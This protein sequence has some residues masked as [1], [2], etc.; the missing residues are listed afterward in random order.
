MAN[1]TWVITYNC[2]DGCKNVGVH[3][4]SITLGDATATARF[5]ITAV[6]NPDMPVED[7]IKLDPEV[8]GEN[9]VV[10]IDGVACTIEK[11]GEEYY[12]QIPEGSAATNMVTYEYHVGDSDDVH[13][14][15]PTSMTVWTL[16]EN[17]D[18]SYSAEHIEDLDDILQYSGSSIRITG[19]KGIRM[20]T[21]IDANKK[22]EL[23]A[24]GLAGYKLLEYGTVV[25]RASNL[26]AGMSLV[27]G[28][29]DGIKSNYAYKRGEADPVFAYDKEN[30]LIQ[31]TNVLV[32]FTLDDCK[33]DI[34]MRSYMIL[35]GA[36][37]VEITIYGGPVY[38]SIGYIAYQNRSVFTPGSAAY[39]YVWEIIHHVYG[40]KYDA[41]YQG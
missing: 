26:Q 27:K 6:Q 21:S 10:C 15:Y 25:A 32:D 3:T 13:T 40:D 30:N 9:V 16:K 41:D 8:T 7:T 4:A 28:G 12:V 11:A 23:I 19:K 14:Q 36:D 35:E 24:N 31:Y 34:A 37:G 29:G 39:N 20:I 17:A 5:S 38:R 22:E 1:N 2:I 18:G 33:D